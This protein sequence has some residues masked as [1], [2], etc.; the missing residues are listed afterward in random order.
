[1]SDIIQSA[2][3]W[4]ALVSYDYVLMWSIVAATGFL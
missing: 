2:A 3:I 1:M 4:R